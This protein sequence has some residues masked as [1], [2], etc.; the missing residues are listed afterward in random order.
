MAV[1]FVIGAMLLATAGCSEGYGSAYSGIRL[2]GGGGAKDKQLS[3]DSWQV[4]Y[5]SSDRAWA[6]DSALYRAAEIAE[7]NGFPAFAA[8]Q[9]KSET[10]PIYTTGYRYVGMSHWVTLVIRGYRG[11]AG[12]CPDVV[13]SLPCT[14]H[15]TAETLQRLAR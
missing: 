6:Y 3:A 11:G 10:V 14:R 8:I 4:R 13:A 12:S 1:R 9:T 2:F 5:N 15:N 7:K